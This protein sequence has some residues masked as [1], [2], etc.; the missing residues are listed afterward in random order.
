M[1]QSVKLLEYQLFHKTCKL[2]LKEPEIRF[3]GFLDPMGN[4]I[5]GGFKKGIK[6]L[7]DESERRKLYMQI[8]LRTKTRQDFD[9]DLGS[10]GYAIARRKKVVT[11]TFQV[12]GTVLFV[13]TQPNIDLDN[14][15]QKIMKICGI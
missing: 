6:P 15:A 5:A 7:H 8:V 12:N 1:L 10:V 11:F 3:S 14:T 9:Y 13:S 2:L 4:L